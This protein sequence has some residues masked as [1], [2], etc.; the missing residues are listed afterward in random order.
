LPGFHPAY[1]IADDDQGCGIKVRL[2]T[3]FTGGRVLRKHFKTLDEA[4]RWI[5]GDGAKLKA[6]PASLLE[7][8][9]KAGAAAFEL[10]PSQ[11]TEAIDAFRRLVGT[12]MTLTQAV[13][14]ALKHS[15]PPAGVIS[16]AEAIEKAVVRKQSRRPTYLAKLENAVAAI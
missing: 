10:T 5:S 11:I 16:V 7:L 12:D 1:G 4:R 14:F 2:G 3:R 13:D 8:K 15:R 9:T 6:T